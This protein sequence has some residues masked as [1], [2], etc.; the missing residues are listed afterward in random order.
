MA[1]GRQTDIFQSGSQNLHLLLN[2]TDPVLQHC[3]KW[4]GKATDQEHGFV[5]RVDE[6]GGGVQLVQRQGLVLLLQ[7]DPEQSYVSIWLLNK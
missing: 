6:V 2:N 4:V 7:E 3:F 5:D 1:S